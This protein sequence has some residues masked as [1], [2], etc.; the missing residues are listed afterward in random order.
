MVALIVCKAGIATETFR[1]KT[2]VIPPGATLPPDGPPDPFTAGG[3]DLTVGDYGYLSD[4]TTFSN[5]L[6]PGAA[7]HEPESST[8]ILAHSV[9]GITYRH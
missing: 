2:V 1:G 5:P 3:R 8:E 4:A 6:V 7:E 9:G